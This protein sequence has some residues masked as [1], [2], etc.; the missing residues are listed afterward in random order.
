[1]VNSVAFA[2]DGQT[3]FASCEDQNI[4]AWNLEEPTRPNVLGGHRAAVNAL[5]IA[6]DGHWLASASQDSTARLWSL[7]G[8]DTAS[9]AQPAPEFSTLLRSEDTLSPALGPVGVWCVAVSPDQFRVAVVTDKLILFD[10]NTR[11]AVASV[12]ATNVYASTNTGFRS[13]TFSPDGR[14]LAVG[15]SDGTAAFL[16]AATLQ[17]LIAPTNLHAGQVADIAYALGGAVLATGGGFGTGVTLTDVASGQILTNFSAVEEGF[18]PLQPLAVSPD[19]KQLATGSPDRLIRL[20]DL[21]TRQLLATCPQKVRFPGCI[22]FSPDG[23]LLAFADTI[24]S[25]YLWDPSGRRPLRPRSGGHSG[26]V[27]ALAFSPDGTLASGGMDHTIRLWHPEL[28]QETAILTGHSGWILRLAFA[29]HG[30]ALVSGSLDGTLKV[31]RA[32]SSEQI[33]AQ[34]RAGVVRRPE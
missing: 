24:G 23:R 17:P 25:L 14:R 5:A 31:W 12:A 4:Y 10:L 7:G 16:D 2:P 1:L 20:W 27:M 15:G 30:N 9:V 33:E 19:G 8:K 32:L 21:T 11:V 13:L 22:A 18:Y 29:E 28:E 34:D 26:G 3:L 6:P